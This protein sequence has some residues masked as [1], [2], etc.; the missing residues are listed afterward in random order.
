MNNDSLNTIVQFRG[1]LH[2]RQLCWLSWAFARKMKPQLCWGKTLLVSV[3]HLKPWASVCELILREYLFLFFFFLAPGCVVGLAF[4]SPAGNPHSWEG[5]GGV[6]GWWDSRMSAGKSFFWVTALHGSWHSNASGNCC[7]D[8]HHLS[9]LNIPERVASVLKIVS[10]LSSCSERARQ[11]LSN[12]GEGKKRKEERKEKKMVRRRSKWV[13][14]K[15]NTDSMSRTRT[16]V[17][18]TP[19]I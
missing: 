6:A 12:G 8:R 9:H 3:H 18:W 1:I 11:P 5:A 4:W 10:F 15:V 17:S 16:H 19:D 7:S 2:P 14:Y 13:I